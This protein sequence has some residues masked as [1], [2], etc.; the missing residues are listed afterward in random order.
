MAA[1][2]VNCITNLLFLSFAVAKQIRQRA[3]ILA[4]RLRQRAI[5]RPNRNSRRST[6]QSIAYN[7]VA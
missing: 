2:N 5:S 1:Y 6:A 3:L 7:R 4:I